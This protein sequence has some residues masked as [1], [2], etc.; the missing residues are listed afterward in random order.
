MNRKLRWGI[1]STANIAERS[2][3]PGIHESEKNE[4]IAVGSRDLQKAKSFGERLNIP[5]TYGRYEQLLEN[6]ENDAVY[7][8]PPNHLH[9]EW[10]IRA[11]QAGKHVLCEN[12][13]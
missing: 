3:I 7:I 8:P 13:I 11:A 9:K 4:V 6:D 2:V 10:T 5:K 1:M 12:P